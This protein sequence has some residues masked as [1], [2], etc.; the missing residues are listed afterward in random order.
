MCV[1]RAT[2]VTRNPFVLGDAVAPTVIPLA[3]NADLKT[4]AGFYARNFT[5]VNPHQ[6]SAMGCALINVTNLF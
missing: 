4:G 3:V 5:A 6:A 2:D 1:G